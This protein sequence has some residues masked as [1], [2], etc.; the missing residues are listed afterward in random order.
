MIRK[1]VS[2]IWTSTVCLADGMLT[3]DIF[4]MVR[5]MNVAVVEFHYDNN[6]VKSKVR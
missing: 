1:V 3:D 5:S 6:I 4:T 2:K